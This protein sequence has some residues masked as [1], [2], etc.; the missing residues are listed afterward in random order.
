MP[1]V[2]R[3]AR[4]RSGRWCSRVDLRFGDDPPAGFEGRTGFK[5][6]HGGLLRIESGVND[7]EALAAAGDCDGAC[8]RS[9][10]DG[11][12]LEDAYGHHGAGGRGGAGH[13][14]EHDLF[15]IV[16]RGDGGAGGEGAREFEAGIAR[17]KAF[18]GELLFLTEI[19]EHAEG[20]I[21][22]QRGGC[23]GG[24]RE[25]ERL[26]RVEADGAEAD[27]GG[28]ERYHGLAEANGRVG[29][30]P[31]A[32]ALGIRQRQTRRAGVFPIGW[33]A[34][35]G[36]ERGGNIGLR[37]RGFVT[38]RD[39][40]RARFAERPEEELHGDL[41]AEDGGTD[42]GELAGERDGSERF[43][44]QQE[45]DTGA[46]ADGVVA[47][48]AD[49][50][51][52]VERAADA[53]AVEV[54][55]EQSADAGLD[56]CGGEREVRRHLELEMIALTYGEGEA[57]WDVE[58]GGRLVIGMEAADG[59]VGALDG[60]VATLGSVI[61]ADA[62]GEFPAPD[63]GVVQLDAEVERIGGAVPESHAIGL[64]VDGDFLGIDLNAR[65]EEHTSELH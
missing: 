14:V 36:G 6:G 12:Q 32:I 34:D 62:A 63:A 52:E 37:S 41:A 10:K 15:E 49:E 60:D 56:G 23:A 24:E 18:A 21:V 48:K 4:K 45:F 47:V 17:F 38:I 43:G 46:G 58:T 26:R 61:D 19:E 2:R 13:G 39:R 1:A 25:R 30:E 42:A 5:H 7:G 44:A 53:E 50:D 35:G 9:R 3:G 51:I 33:G 11:S 29:R 40:E 20:E 59:D 22:L 55:F 65:S 64:D 27:D 16:L 8:G 54:R 57:G 31:D 28:V